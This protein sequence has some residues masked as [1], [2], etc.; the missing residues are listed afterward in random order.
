MGRHPQKPIPQ[1]V[2]LFTAYGTVVVM[3]MTMTM[4]MMMAIMTK[5]KA[6]STSLTMHSTHQNS[7]RTGSSCSKP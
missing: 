4:K 5:S 6:S 7:R 1:Q 3:M 2:L